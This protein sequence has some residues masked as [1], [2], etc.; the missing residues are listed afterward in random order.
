LALEGYAN[1]AKLLSGGLDWYSPAVLTAGAMAGLGAVAIAIAVEAIAQGRRAYAGVL[2]LAVCLS[3]SSGLY[4]SFESLLLGRETFAS[5]VKKHNAAVAAAKIAKDQA[6]AEVQRLNEAVTKETLNKGCKSICRGLQAQLVEARSVA[7]AA[8]DDLAKAGPVR[9]ENIVAETLGVPAVAAEAT[10]TMLTA[11]AL[12]AFAIL[13]PWFAH[14]GRQVAVEMPSHVSAD[15]T[16]DVQSE[17]AAI[18]RVLEALREEAQS[19]DELARRLGV[20]KGT[21]SKWA[22][23]AEDAGL[24]RR[25]R[26]G[27][28][29]RIRRVA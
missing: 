14:S 9:A 24:I 13:L 4:N 2:L 17:R 11:F 20:P 12:L 16:M 27:R 28:E 29:V 25:H 1:V 21:A 19:N 3:L 23:A 7:Q 6:D 15:A 5:D 8:A 22:T 10:P 26:D 18:K